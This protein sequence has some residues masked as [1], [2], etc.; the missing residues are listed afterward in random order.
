MFF[1][2]K[3]EF[4]I[5]I[6]LGGGCNNYVSS[7]FRNNNGKIVIGCFSKFGIF[8]NKT[9]PNFNTQT[10][11][12]YDT[13]ILILD[14]EGNVINQSAY[15]GNNNNFLTCVP[16]GNSN[17]DLPLV[18]S[19]ISPSSG[20]NTRCLWLLRYLAGQIDASQNLNTSEIKMVSTMN[21][22]PNALKDVF[23]VQFEEI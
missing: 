19:S 20:K 8:G 16:Y 17:S 21:I 23:K 18:S 7:L 5:G 9:S 22:Y 1:L 13:W 3:N 10:L 12:T 6:A 14:S 4:F 2:K 11:S 15:G